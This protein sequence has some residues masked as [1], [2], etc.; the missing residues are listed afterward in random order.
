MAG[1][2]SR[3]VNGPEVVTE[4]TA[5]FVYWIVDAH[6][7]HADTATPKATRNQGVHRSSLPNLDVDPIQ[8]DLT[9]LSAYVF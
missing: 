7:T 9:L 1:T 5:P 3:R 4:L 2:S 6:A 8:I